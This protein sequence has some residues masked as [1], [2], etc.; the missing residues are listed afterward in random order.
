LLLVPPAVVV[1]LALDQ[2]GFDPSTWVWS[3]ALAAGRCDG[4]GRVARARAV[5]HRRAWPPRHVV[6]AWVA[7][8][9]LWS[10]RRVQTV[11]EARRT[12]VYAAVVLALVVLV[13][14]GTVGHVLAATHGAIVAVVV[15][16]LARYLT[17][18]RT[19]DAFEG[20]LL[21][22]PLGYAKRWRLWR[23]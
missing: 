14:R 4:R 2:G 10:D 3:G 22:Q 16:A 12:A 8:S 9:W 23:R 20:A 7:A 21:V 18:T 6:L 19:L 5:T 15:Y 1:A 11:L 17:E 13:R